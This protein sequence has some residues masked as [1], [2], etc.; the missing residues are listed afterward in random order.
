MWQEIIVGICVLAAVL[1]LLRQWFFKKNAACGGC[2]NCSTA[3][4]CNN[5][6]DKN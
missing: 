2:N 1:F 3:P 4:K 6:Q 5:P